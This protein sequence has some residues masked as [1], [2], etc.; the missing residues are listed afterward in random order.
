MIIN[1][2]KIGGFKNID[3]TT[4]QLKN[5][6]ALVGL[7]N[8]GKS[9]MLDA[10]DFA[11]EFIKN[12]N[13]IKSSM[14]AY[15]KGMPINTVLVG[16]NFDFE[17]EYITKFNN[18]EFCVCYGFSFKWM[19]SNSGGSIES[20]LLKIKLN[21]KGNKYSDYIKRNNE[22]CF[23]RSSQTG[24]CSTVIK[25]E[26]DNLVVNKV[27]NFDD[28]FYLD[29]IK[30]LNNI[31]FDLNS[32]LDTSTAF[33]SLPI[34]IKSSNA[35]YLDKDTGGNIAKIVYTL[36]KN[37]NDKYN[38][39]INS[40]L[41]LFPDIESI[42]PQ[43]L[44]YDKKHFKVGGLKDSPFM[45]ADNIFIIMVKEKYNI[46][47][48]NFNNLSNGTKRIFILLTSAI[49]A[50][51]QGI[52]IIAFE[53]LEN[54][55]HPALFQQLLIILSNIIDNIRIII[56]SHSP[57]LIQYLDLDNI[58]I[59]IPSKNGIAK[60]TRIKKSKKSVVTNNA[61]DYNISTGDYIFEMLVNSFND[62]DSRKELYSYLEVEKRK[63]LMK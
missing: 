54:C 17:M 3:N 49:L 29:I 57:Y 41:S 50:D 16:K 53:E 21:K 15:V 58:Y 13:G 6:T 14:M 26:K 47:P 8:Y 22:N 56:T 61:S 63:K 24:R 35:Y 32:F 20:E 38:L 19:T 4:I 44:S 39:L 7:N 30:E 60:F 25:I 42:E 59:G 11:K 55:I 9:N 37:N 31:N 10:I 27:A 46:K 62:D 48:E 45:L 28:L 2:I 23:Y 5:I 1:K 34:Q 12:P 36:K 43:M 18:K 51:I 33:N 40:F 52:N